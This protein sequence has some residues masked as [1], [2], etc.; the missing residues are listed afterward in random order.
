MCPQP[1]TTDN[2][3]DGSQ[4]VTGLQ[5]LYTQGRDGGS[6]KF[7]QQILFIFSPVLS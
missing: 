6:Q 5:K 2:M 4:S 3:A 7:F 1:D